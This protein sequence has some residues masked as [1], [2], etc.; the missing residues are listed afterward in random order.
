MSAQQEVAQCVLGYIVPK[1]LYQE[2]VIQDWNFS[3]LM[4]MKPLYNQ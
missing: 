3:E 4:V 2:E 1:Y